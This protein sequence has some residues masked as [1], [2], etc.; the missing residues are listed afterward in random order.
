MTRSLSVHGKVSCLTTWL[1]LVAGLFL[2]FPGCAEVTPDSGGSNKKKES[3][4]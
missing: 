4:I 1:L 3:I 2:T